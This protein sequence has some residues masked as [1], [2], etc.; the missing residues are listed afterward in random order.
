MGVRRIGTTTV[1]VAT[2]GRLQYAAHADINPAP[3][4]RT[5]RPSSFWRRSTL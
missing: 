5:N 3:P 2:G 1:P 4:R